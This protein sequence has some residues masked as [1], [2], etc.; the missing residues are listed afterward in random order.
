[1]ARIT[2]E[3]CLKTGYNKFELVHLVAKRVIQFRKG[4]EPLLTT[5]NREIVTALREIA[6][7]KIKMRGNSNLIEDNVAEKD[8]IGDDLVE[9]SESP[10]K[11]DDGEVSRSEEPL[12]NME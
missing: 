10:D 11:Q 1:M 8:L 5:T 9:E 7:G 4:K 12:D 3:D 2:I 6:A